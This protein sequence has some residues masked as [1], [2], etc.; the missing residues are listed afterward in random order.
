RWT[1]V[2]GPA[3]PGGGAGVNRPQAIVLSVLVAAALAVC[4]GGRAGLIVGVAAALRAGA[5]P[6]E[7]A[8]CVATAIGGTTGDRLGRVARAL[9]MG[10]A[11]DEAWSYLGA[12]SAP[13]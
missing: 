9:R 7:A 3:Q 13:L 8:R 5:A 2:G 1:G 12:T 6:E 11:A 4:V 10:A